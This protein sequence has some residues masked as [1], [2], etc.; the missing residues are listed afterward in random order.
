[1]K[2]K[3]KIKKRRFLASLITGVITITFWYSA[4]I[5]FSLFGHEKNDWKKITAQ[6]SILSGV[7]KKK[8]KAQLDHLLRNKKH[9][10][11]LATN[12]A[13]YLQY[14]IQQTHQQ[15]VPI[16]LA[17]LPMLESQFQPFSFS[18]KGATG[19]WQIMP[20]TASGYGLT[21]DWWYDGRRDTVESTRAALSYLNYLHNYFRDWLLAIAAY[22]AGEGRVLRAIHE[23]MKKQL[24][25]DYWSL[26]LPQQTQD[27][28]PL[29]LA[30]IEIFSHPEKYQ[31]N[32]HAS[33]EVTWERI[34]LPGPMHL[35]QVALMAGLSVAALRVYNPGYR[36]DITGPH[37]KSILIPEYAA[38]KI[39]EK[40]GSLG[41]RK[42]L[43]AR[44]PTYVVRKGD[45]LSEIAEKNHTTSSR[46]KFFNHLNDDHIK[47][48]Q[49]LYIPQHQKMPA[50]R[51]EKYRSD[52]KINTEIISEASLPGPKQIHYLV[53]NGDTYDKIAKNFNVK[54][55][56]LIYWNGLRLDSKL[57]P[58]Q[59][60]NLFQRT[61]GH[62]TISHRVKFGDSL[63]LLAIKYHTTV[64][65]IK[66]KNN[67]QNDKIRVNQEIII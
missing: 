29:F 62:L 35:S 14:I 32:I 61:S 15:H 3:L 18:Q 8:F 65:K 9:L 54:E 12:A 46:I 17:L 44:W 47:I 40:L 34:V 41:K 64:E 36:H 38:K 55:E 13:P 26:H 58:G 53:R 37:F 50:V 56:Q 2:S 31:L 43:I 25:I 23:N 1:M 16:E 10:R 60:L 39:Q 67:L 4:A 42:R 59:H 19:L 52:I 21:L 51:S 11:E 20:E 27:Y 45:S 30:Y 57:I 28:I 33:S 7:D 24:P 5:S 66:Q 6:D 48:N 63:S 22:N 49:R